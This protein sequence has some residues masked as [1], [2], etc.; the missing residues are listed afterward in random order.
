M[1]VSKTK[2]NL[3]KFVSTTGIAA[4]SDAEPKEKATVAVQ[5]KQVE[6]INQLGGVVNGIAA[7]LIKI[8]E[9]ELARARALAKKAREFKPDYTTPKK[10][11]AN[12]ATRMMEAFKAPNFLKGL[13]QML[14]ALFKMF[15]GIP[16]LKWF[17]DPRNREKIKLT[18]MA[19]WAVLTVLQKQCEAM[20]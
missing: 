19:L 20:V 9:I 14:G 2:I 12:F 18:L 8:E 10:I 3:Y 16:I 11:K 1:N 17:A 6:A 7:S 15:V 4:A 5:E 13:L